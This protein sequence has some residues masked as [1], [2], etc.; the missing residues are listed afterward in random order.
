[1]IGVVFD[2]DGVLFDTTDYHYRSWKSVTAPLGVPFDKDVNERLRGLSR[3]KSLEVILGDRFT[4]FSPETLAAMTAE[5]N[6][7]YL[8]M[9]SDLTEADGAPGAGKL[10]EELRAAGCRLAVASSSRNAKTLLK[11]LGL[12][13]FFDV[14][15]DGNDVAAS[16]PDPEVFLKAVEELGLAPRRCIVVEDAESGVEAAR[17]AGLKSVGVGNPAGLAK[18]DITVDSIDALDLKILAALAGD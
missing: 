13:Q 8:E 16:K 17:A 4:E 10:L 12:A 2:F 5:K 15:I 18:A 7:A 1:M 9:M 3:E 14:L 6:R 11:R